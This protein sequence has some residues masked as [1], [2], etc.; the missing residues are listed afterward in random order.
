M[1]AL[2]TLG[3]SADRI[4]VA[5]PNGVKFGRPVGTK[6]RRS[7][8]GKLDHKAAGWKISDLARAVWLA[9]KTAYEVLKAA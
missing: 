6:K 3:A 1:E 4:V 5:K 7:P 2:V 8:D 9:R